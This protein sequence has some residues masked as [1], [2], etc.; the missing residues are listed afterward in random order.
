MHFYWE[1]KY[2][3]HVLE[4]MPTD[5][6]STSQEH[7]TPAVI[8]NALASFLPNDSHPGTVHNSNWKEKTAPKDLNTV[9]VSDTGKTTVRHE[10]CCERNRK[11]N[12]AAKKYHMVPRH[13]KYFRY[14]T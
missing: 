13:A 7:Y 3:V 5:P 4:S 14:E 2:T 8:S 12:E 1:E 10:H 6:P 9:L 11:R